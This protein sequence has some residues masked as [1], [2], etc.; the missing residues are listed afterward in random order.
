MIT[1]ISLIQ[2]YPSLAFWCV[3][4]HTMKAYRG[5]RGIAPLILSLGIPAVL[6]AS[7][8]IVSEHSGGFLVS[9]FH[10]LQFQ[11]VKKYAEIL[12]KNSI[13]ACK[14]KNMGA[15]YKLPMLCNSL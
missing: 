2:F 7:W 12:P 8:Q 1:V 6:Q 10:F 11:N 9:N 3:P 4:V 14:I 13:G 15:V 5:S